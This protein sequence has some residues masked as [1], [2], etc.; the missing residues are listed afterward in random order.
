MSW[1][2]HAISHSD[3]GRRQWAPHGAPLS[4][5]TRKSDYYYYYH[6]FDDN[7]SLHKHA[8]SQR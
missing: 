6:R 7:R 2:D 8:H 1:P 4:T 5:H 3:D